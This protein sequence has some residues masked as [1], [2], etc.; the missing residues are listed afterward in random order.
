MKDK[1]DKKDL[2]MTG[3]A[4]VCIG[5]IALAPTIPLVL[6]TTGITILIFPTII[7][8]VDK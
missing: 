6:L 1:L 8:L 2:I 4:S 5:A 3:A 7:K